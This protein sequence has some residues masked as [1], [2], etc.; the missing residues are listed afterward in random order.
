MKAQT[1]LFFLAIL[2]FISAIFIPTN[3]YSQ[4]T[5]SGN[6]SEGNIVYWY[7]INLRILTDPQTKIQS[8]DVRLIGDQISAGTIKEYDIKLW[9]SLSRG[10]RIP[11]GPF[12]RYDEANQA[13]KFYK[14]G[15]N[16]EQD[17]LFNSD[18]QVFW[19]ILHVKKRSRSK[20]FMLIR[21]PGAIA[22]GD[23][24]TFKS[25]LEGNLNLQVLTIGPFWDQP[26]AEESK[27]RYRLH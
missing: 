27:R 7:Y 22:S 2:F 12:Y 25:F 4:V 15:A 11:V 18:R 20:S 9:E 14:I 6:M 16:Q 10:S 23:Y 1:K 8:Y 17:S 21:K 3:T 19:F 26:E 5:D 24:D 13:K